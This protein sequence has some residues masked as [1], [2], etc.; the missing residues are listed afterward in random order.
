MWRRSYLL[1]LD[2]KDPGSNPGGCQLPGAVLAVQR[3]SFV[4]TE[5]AKAVI[6]FDSAVIYG[7]YDGRYS[8][9]LSR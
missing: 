5:S 1:F 9:G 6:I 3:D 4:G 7:F 8:S 2:A